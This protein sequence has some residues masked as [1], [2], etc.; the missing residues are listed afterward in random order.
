MQLL[1]EVR[2]GELQDV[3]GAEEVGLELVADFVLV[4]VFTRSDDSW[5]FWA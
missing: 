2:Q 1:A 5:G 3:E 4:L